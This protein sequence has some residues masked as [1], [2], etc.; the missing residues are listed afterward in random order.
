MKFSLNMLTHV[1]SSEKSFRT[2]Y[3]TKFTLQCLTGGVLDFNHHT[4]LSTPFLEKRP[5]N[6]TC[7]KGRSLTCDMAEVTE[8]L[9]FLNTMYTPTCTPTSI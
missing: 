2:F 5:I 1:N 3:L 9:L 7:N 4:I 8:G 6:T